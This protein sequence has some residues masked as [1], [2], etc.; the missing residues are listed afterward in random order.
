MGERLLHRCT[1]CG[2]GAWVSGGRDAGMSCTTST[3][4]CAE[5]REIRDV[6][7][8]VIP[9]SGVRWLRRIPIRCRSC[10]GGEDVLTEWVT[11]GPCPKCAA[12]M[13][14]RPDASGELWD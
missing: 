4:T 5:C 6:M 10:G 7:R 13:E 3:M 12:P 14:V 2:Y 8:S 11:G 9:P 1:V